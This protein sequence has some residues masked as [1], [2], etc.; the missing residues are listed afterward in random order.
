MAVYTIDHDTIQTMKPPVNNR[1]ILGWL[2]ENLFNGVFNSVLTLVAL[3]FLIK[4]VPPFINWAFVNANW[5]SAGTACKASDGAC[6]SVVLKNQRFV[7]FG[8]YPHDL[9]WRPLPP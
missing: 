8:F 3:A 1:G 6:W 2:K 9:H 5:F 7:I 4:F